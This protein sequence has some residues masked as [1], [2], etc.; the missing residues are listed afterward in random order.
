MLRH[1]WLAAA[2]LS[3]LAPA[4]AAQR[5]TGAP[6]PADGPGTIALFAPRPAAGDV[7]LSVHFVDRSF[8]GVTSWTWEFGDSQTSHL[9]DPTHVYTAG[10]VYDVRLTVTGPP[11][12]ASLTKPGAVVA[13]SCPHESARDNRITPLERGEDFVPITGDDSLGFYCVYSGKAIGPD[14][15]RIDNNVGMF[16]LPLVNGEVLLFGSGYGDRNSFVEPTESADFDVRRVDAIIRFCLEREPAS[17][18]IHFVAPH[19]HIDHI[20]ADCMRELRRRGYRIVEILFHSR[21]STWAKSMPGWTDE[22]RAVFR[23]LRNATDQCQ[24]ELASFASPLG[25]IWFFLRDGHTPGS[26]DL[27]IDV[28][29]D[30]ANRFI[31]RGSGEIYG[32]CPLSGV[33]EAI[34]PH[35]N[36]RLTAPEP[37][38]LALSPVKGS[39][40]GGT[41]VVLTG[42]DFA[43]PLAGPPLV[44]FDGSPASAVK[45]LA[46]DTLTC[47]VP[48]GIPGAAVD[49]RLINKNGQA[50]GAGAFT[51]RSFPT[52]DGAVPARGLATGGTRVTLSGTS[53]EGS[54]STQVRFGGVLATSVQVLGDG[55]LACTA[56]PHAPGTVSV[57][58]SNANGSAELEAGFLYDPVIDV[59][60]VDPASGSALGGK[61]VRITGAACEVSSTLP[62]V[63]FGAARANAVAR[64]SDVL[65]ECTTPAG[66]NGTAVDV[67]VSGGNGADAIAGGFRY[68]P[69]P[70]VTAVDPVSG[71]EAGGTLVTITGTGFTKDAAGTNR[72]NFGGRPATGVE[73]VSDTT[74]RCLA[75]AGTGGARVE[76]LVTN[77]NGTGRLVQGYRYHRPPVLVSLAPEKGRRGGG[78]EVTLRG[79]G[80]QETGAGTT[81]VLF[82][83]T[84]APGVS[85]VDDATLTC[86]TP[87]MTGDGIVDVEVRNA[88]GHALLGQGFR[89]VTAPA[90]FGLEPAAGPSRGGNQVTLRG[91]GFLAAGAGAASVRFGKEEAADVRVLDDA[92][93]TCTAPFGLPGARADVLLANQN[94]GA[95]LADAYLYLAL[96]TLEH[97]SPGEGRMAGG[98][99]VRLTGSGFAGAGVPVVRF[100][101]AEA[102]DVV[103]Q[104]EFLLECTTPPGD[105]GAVNVT[106]R[107]PGGLAM[108]HDGF[109][110]GSTVPVI[111][112]LGPDHGTSLGG[113]L[114]EIHGASFLASFAGPNTVRF[115]GVPATSVLALSD[116]RLRCESPPGAPGALVGVSV[117]NANGSAVRAAAYRYAL[118]PELSGVAPAQGSALG[119]FL[120][121]LRGSGFARDEAR[122]LAVRFGSAAAT[123]VVVLDDSTL[124]CRAPQG[125]PDAVVDL[126]LSSSNGP[127]RLAGAFHYLGAPVLETIAPA[128][129]SPLGGTR[130]TLG[131]SNFGAAGPVTEHF[132]AK[133]ATEVVL[134]GDAS[135]TCSTPAGEPGTSVDVRL[136]DQNGAGTLARA[137]RYHSVPDIT[138]VAPGNGPAA[139]GTTVVLTGSG[140]TADA[141]GVNAVTFGGKPARSVITLDDM[142]VRAVVPT[143]IA[144]ANVE[145]VLSNS[146][147]SAQVQAY[148]YNAAPA[149][150]LLEPPAASSLG[151]TLVT[152]RG[153]GFQRD[154]AGVNAVLFGATAAGGVSVLDDATLTCLAPGGLAGS[155]VAVSLTNKNGTASAQAPFRYHAVPRIDE[156]VPP[157]GFS[158][159]G[160]WIEIRGAG[161]LADEAG[162]NAVRFGS[163][164]ASEVTVVDD[165]ILR[166]RAPAGAPGPVAVEVENRNGSAALADGFYYDWA[167]TL[168]GFQP[169]AGS[170]LGG[171][172]VLLTG[173]GF[174]TP[175]AGVTTVRFGVAPATNVRVQDGESLLCTAPFGP[176][177]GSVSVVA[178]NSHG[179]S[180]LGG[181]RYHPRPT[182]TGVEPG[183]GE[184]GGGTVVTLHGTGF[185]AN[186][187]GNPSVRFDGLDAGGVTVLDDATAQCTAPAGPSRTWPRITLANANGEA[188]FAGGFRWLARDPCDLDDDGIG[189]ALL[190]TADSVCL[191]FG[192]MS[193]AS[194]ESSL[195][196]DLVLR[197]AST[198]TDFGAQV[199]SGD[200]HA[201]QI[202]D[203]VVSAPIDDVAGADAGAVFVFHGPLAGS[204]SARMAS[205][206]S[207]IFRGAAAGDHFGA[208]VCVRD[209]TGDGARDLL[210]GAPLSDAGFSDGGAVYVFRG[211][212]G[213]T[214]R[215]T[216]QATARLVAAGSQLLFGSALG[217]GDVNGDGVADVVVGAP[218]Q[219]TTGGNSGGAYV[220]RGGASLASAPA[221]SAQVQITGT[222]SG[223]KL[224]TSVGVADF[225]G[226]GTEDVFLGAPEAKNTGVQGGSVYCFR[227]A[228]MVS[229]SASGAFARLDGENSGDR[230][231]QVL[232]LGDA[233]GD[234]RADLLVS[235]PQHDLPAANAGRAYL[236]LGRGLASGSIAARARTILVAENSV[237]DQ[238]GTALG[239]CDFDGD[240]LADL[241][242][243]APFSNGGGADAGRVHVFWGASLQATRSGGA[244]DVTYTG[245][246]AALVLGREVGGT[247]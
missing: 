33:R 76:V 27:V 37:R 245:T 201:D 52:L 94:G 186:A 189:D 146:N 168:A 235:A 30:P 176:A 88:N 158:G 228:T 234:G 130:V 8:G 12:T 139:G 206:A 24:E 204:P 157:F 16:I 100:A 59:Q 163:T 99:R 170:S 91:E 125:S 120:V 138:S 31:V 112:E 151:G 21:D 50:L 203:L 5:G 6:R 70:R 19:G 46:D 115:G 247:R 132:G 237:G 38:L 47:T 104:S 55:S 238:F 61:R 96:P 241:F 160:E 116:T 164:A 118:L 95:R 137:Y 39:A 212:A 17:T 192:S 26:I 182:L 220:F 49:V 179:S 219:G 105:R 172:E 93:L 225:D 40:L 195:A 92:R 106:V 110:Y 159:G 156:L 222:S 213:F 119:G 109:V 69:A 71:A 20:N 242:V 44:L 111:D 82:G 136:E 149:I 28:R 63:F 64:L 145:L 102:V 122:I 162:P 190:S 177:G 57:A 198:G 144:G 243:G 133:V 171:T 14:N 231:G 230:L 89:F 218:E 73:T 227:G 65:L 90:L 153:S 74:I 214:G 178:S 142:R 36:L 233:D 202:A 239:L 208:S 131:G 129:G 196:A 207:A 188:S 240:G 191:F 68:F 32:T 121:T 97:V 60:S 75:P 80:F 108:L 141:A 210:V 84:P 221:S 148:R 13:R 78:A 83:G 161:W 85:V 77:A 135:L 23:T 216:A 244:D 155:E 34:E 2:V 217:S 9:P 211:G 81:A 11:R 140:F 180:S 103:V 18:P 152:I 113:T 134:L 15:A 3:S 86:T 67:R 7:P 165:A 25:K 226:D 10:G 199:T 232:A 123:E 4:A 117:A 205:T 101:A 185:S 209:V 45:V 43:A 62:E 98:N 223:D 54:Q 22:D 187:A 184:P 41:E 87:A 1:A 224:G 167:P 79:S 200:L 174:A 175:G 194:D 169:G 150:G 143:G 53:F 35:G 127:A 48:P 181:F 29:N 154:G 124:T 246:S 229:G 197:Q 56:P 72:V 107:T 114:V 126:E 166:C 193:G 128:S 236:V 147:G 58:L 183:I 66:S 51:Y 215:T 42:Q 173:G